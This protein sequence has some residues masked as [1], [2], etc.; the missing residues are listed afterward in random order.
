MLKILLVD[1][2]PTV[3][4]GMLTCIDW[5]SHGFTIVGE[6]NNGAVALE[7]ALELRP[8]II[9]SDICM[10]V[11]DGI[12][13]V[14]HL[15]E[16]LPESKIIIMSGYDEFAYAKSLMGMKV[17][18]Y[19]LKPVAEEELIEV[20]NKLAAEI[21]DEEINKASQETTSKLLYESFPQI[22][23]K[24][25]AKI[26]DGM[27]QSGDELTKW[28]NVIKVKL[29]AVNCQYAVIMIALDNFDAIS[30]KL[31]ADEQELSNFAVANIAEEIINE[32]ASGFLCYHGFE[33]FTG[34]ICMDNESPCDLELICQRIAVSLKE[35]WKQKAFI[36]MGAPT[37]A[38]SDIR[39]SYLEALE[40][41]N[42]KMFKGKRTIIQIALRY[43]EDNYDKDLSLAA[44][45]KA[46]YVTPN[47][48][49][50]VFKEEM[51]TNFV[52]WLNQ[53]RI[54]KAKDLLTFTGL[55]AYEIAEKV[56]YKDYKYFSAMFKKLTG[57]SPKDYPQ[58]S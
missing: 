49:S 1:D 39:R 24:F 13:L 43:I 18:D 11:M 54:D 52:D 7:K 31:S 47:Y 35:Y 33:N 23:A 42:E 32:N 46:A 34:L 53:L 56:G 40:Q 19:L 8:H 25:M 51:N 57:Y 21:A 2:E 29:N 15:K 58:S 22:K 20:L 17:T 28:A 41:L 50:R 26:L 6:A 5:S 36:G 10:P 3:R 45:A 12:E 37:A 9:L 30:G 27:F 48:L 38:V 44:V 14:Q 4:K 16:Q 55:K